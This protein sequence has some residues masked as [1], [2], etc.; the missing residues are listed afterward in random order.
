MPS[1]YALEENLG[2]RIRYLA[3]KKLDDRTT[4]KLKTWV[5]DVV[6]PG[7][8]MYQLELV[9]DSMSTQFPTNFE[10]FTEAQVRRMYYSV[11]SESDLDKL[12]EKEWEK[13]R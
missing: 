10:D 12:I 4:L 6:S 9:K 1:D 3:E 13:R 2:E 11:R 7:K 8:R 5:S